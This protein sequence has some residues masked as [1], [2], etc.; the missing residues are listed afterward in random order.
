MTLYLILAL[1][2]GI[3]AGLFLP[4]TQNIQAKGYVTTRLPEQRPQAIQ[5]VI[6]GRLEK[7][8][9]RE[10]DF[11]E[12]GDTIIYISEVKSEYFD[13]ELVARTSEQVKAKSESIQTYDDKVQFLENQYD[14]LRAALQLKRE[15]TRNKIQQARNKIAIDSI[16]LVAL[17]A[18][19]Q[20]AQNQLSRTQEL[21]DKGLKS[22]TE[23]QEKELKQQQSSAKVTGQKNKLLNQKNELVNAIIELSA[24]EKEYFDKLA[25]SR[26]DQQSAVASKLESIAATS[27]LQN[28]LSNLM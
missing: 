2:L 25:K 4:W 3:F 13:P 17:E 20:I 8:Y 16:D 28:Q 6:S 21:Y 9:V 19:L 10:G 22:L 23:L 11:V 24:V 26:S 27:K 14:A 12:A 7:W 1:I 18:N 5:S 15:Q